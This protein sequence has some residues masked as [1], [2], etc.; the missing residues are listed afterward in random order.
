MMPWER[1]RADVAPFLEGPQTLL[2][3]EELLALL[4][5]A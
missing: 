1:V 4:R 2:T 5:R 3:R